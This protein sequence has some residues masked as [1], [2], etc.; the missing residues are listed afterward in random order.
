MTQAGAAAFDGLAQ[1]YDAQFTATALGRTLRDMA[2]RRFER[3]FARCEY[4]LDI[5]CGT[6]EDAIRMASLGHRV[7]ATDASS[8][9]IRVATVKAERAGVAQRVRFLCV[10]ME[11]VGAELEGERFDG[12]Y[13]NFGAINCVP[14]LGAL[15]RSLAP[16]LPPLSTLALVVMGRYV[17]WEWAWYLARAQPANAFRR[18][19]RGGVAWRGLTVSYPTPPQLARAL[20]PSFVTRT[21]EPMGFALPGSYAAA[22]LERSP[23]ALTL[24]TRLEQFAQRGGGLASFSDHYYFEALRQGT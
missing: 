23:R 20:A 19:R 21:Y 3:T 1:D 5:G 24:L 7:L 16:L 11:R 4:L 2:W 6:G 13:S 17:P 14:E 9:M 18:L 12:A 22:W 15:A 10:P 8:Q